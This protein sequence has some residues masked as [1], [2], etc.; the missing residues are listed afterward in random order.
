MLKSKGLRFAL[1]GLAVFFVGILAL[2]VS[3][4]AGVVL[5]L[6]GGMAVWGGFI[7]TLIGYYFSPQPPGDD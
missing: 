5:I 6:A 2:L 4:V 3:K 1:A 7:G